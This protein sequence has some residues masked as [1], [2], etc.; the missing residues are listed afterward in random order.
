MPRIIATYPYVPVASG[1]KPIV[2]VGLAANERF[3][4]LRAAPTPERMRTGLAPS[5]G[6]RV[7]FSDSQAVDLQFFS[8]DAG[9][10]GRL[11]TL[12]PELDRR[13]DDDARVGEGPSIQYPHIC[14]GQDFLQ[15]FWL[16]LLGPIS[17]TQVYEPLDDELTE[18]EDV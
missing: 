7:D 17:L 13:L 1:G 9:P 3:T 2:F 6:A 15:N 8:R 12:V 10:V 18:G 16:G 11:V 5:A 4:L 14:L